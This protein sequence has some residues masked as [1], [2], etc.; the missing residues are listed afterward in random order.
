MVRGVCHHLGSG[1]AHA[2][3]SWSP[4]PHLPTRPWR[5]CDERT[6][7]WASNGVPPG[8]QGPSEQAYLLDHGPT[9]LG[10]AALEDL[11]I[12]HE[13]LAVVFG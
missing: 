10:I 2:V 8:A 4:A 12:A 3:I 7:S 1:V 13:H 11:A 9:D 5:G 6:S